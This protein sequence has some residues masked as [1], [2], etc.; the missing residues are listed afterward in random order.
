MVRACP[1]LLALSLAGCALAQDSSAS[2][3]DYTIQTSPPEPTSATSSETSSAAS[4]SSDANSST[5]AT[6]T[7]VDPASTS[8]FP[9]TCSSD[10][11]VIADA[12]SSCG[13]GTTLNTT[14]LCTVDVEQSYRS[15][16]QCALAMDPTIGN[17]STYQAM[18][19][20][21]I[22]Q[23]ASAS[24]NPITLPPATIT[25][26]ANAT[27]TGSTNG[28]NGTITSTFSNSTSATVNTSPT[29]SIVSTTSSSGASSSAATS[30]AST[31]DAATSSG[32]ASSAEEKAVYNLGVG[33][34]GLM[35]AVLV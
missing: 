20:T 14:C 18:L 9:G 21:Y 27:T 16:L 6:T 8:A 32:A 5:T 34:V 30:A 13:V 29:T 25:L 23:C 17:Q 11:Q 1:I 4:S 12:L 15:C 22:N 33:L 31:A 2:A 3:S 10:C 24:S 26:P 35:V 19:D 7:S 28:T